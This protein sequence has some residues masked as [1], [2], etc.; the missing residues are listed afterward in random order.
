MVVEAGRH[1]PRPR[2]APAR[3]ATLGVQHAAWCNSSVHNSA[4]P[5]L[6]VPRTWKNSVVRSAVTCILYSCV[7]SFFRE[8]LRPMRLVNQCTVPRG[9]VADSRTICCTNPKS[10][11]G[12][13]ISSAVP[14]CV[15]ERGGCMVQ[16]HTQHGKKVEQKTKNERGGFMYILD[17]QPLCPSAPYAQATVYHTTRY[18]QNRCVGCPPLVPLT[19]RMVDY[20]W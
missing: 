18:L 8:S 14:V 11:P 20:T 17:A 12:H 19:Q 13:T 9:R 10:P 4:P 16:V 7:R 1:R 3:S 2:Y 6:P 5:Q 15:G